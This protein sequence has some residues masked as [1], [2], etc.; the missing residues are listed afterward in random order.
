MNVFQSGLYMLGV[1]ALMVYSSRTVTG[2][3]LL[4]LLS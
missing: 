3:I 2:L 4:Q 1:L